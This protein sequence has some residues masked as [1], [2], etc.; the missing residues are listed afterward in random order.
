VNI[1]KKRG[2]QMLTKIMKWVSLAAL[3]L[4]LLWRSSAGLLIAVE[5]VVS[6]GAL[7][8]VAQALRARK[9]V[10]GAGFMAIAVLFNPVAPFAL[11][12]TMFL[13]LVLITMS[14][15]LASM[16]ALKRQ[17]LISMPSI[18]NLK[19]GRESF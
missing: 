4:A 12:R 11:S 8:V 16:A 1:K 9:Y 3:M 18:A 10:W 7:L 14:A 5:L 19:P 2:S 6:V 15:F 17:P 13:S